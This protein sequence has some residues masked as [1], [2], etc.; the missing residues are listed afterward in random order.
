MGL[1]HF[2]LDKLGKFLENVHR[3][4]RLGG[5]FIVREHD[6]REELKPMLDCAHSVFN[7]VTGV[8]ERDERREIRAFRSVREWITII[9]SY[10]FKDL[11]I[12]EMQS[13]DPTEDYMLCFTKTESSGPSLRSE[14]EK[15]VSDLKQ[16][17]AHKGLVVENKPGYQTFFTLPEWFLVDVMKRYGSYM[18]H[19]PW[20]EFPYW[21][22][23]LLFWSLALQ[24]F[25]QVRKRQGFSGALFNSYFLMILVL[26]GII[27]MLFTQLGVL[28]IVPWFIYGIIYPE[29]G[30]VQVIAK[31]DTQQHNLDMLA[32]V[33]IK[34]E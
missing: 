19:T 23:I 26:G 5:V 24:E 22:E 15:T 11:G 2:P 12:Y 25:L 20:Y 4:L 34:P 17:M 16:K 9:E 6:G 3:I 30:T 33:I 28:A 18:E 32:Q 1:H 8:E 31:I 13:N 29:V 7:A 27:T 14:N 21:R 10:G